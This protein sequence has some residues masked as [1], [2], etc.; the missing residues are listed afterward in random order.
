MYCMH[1]TPQKG[2]TD[3]CA[4]QAIAGVQV[5]AMP[6]QAPLIA[7]RTGNG[8]VGFG[9]PGRRASRGV[10]GSPAGWNPGRSAATGEPL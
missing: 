4:L 9:L 3:V 6:C 1:A 5:P 7:L 8:L 10:R 2:Y